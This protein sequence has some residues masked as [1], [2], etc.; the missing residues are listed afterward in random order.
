[1]P[2]ELATEK[3]A[4]SKALGSRPAAFTDAGGGLQRLPGYAGAMQKGLHEL[5]YEV[6]TETNL[7]MF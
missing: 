4:S 2:K 1:M 7:E 5:V 3:S 6:S